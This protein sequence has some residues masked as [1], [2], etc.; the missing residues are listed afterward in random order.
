MGATR[1]VNFSGISGAITVVL[2]W[3]YGGLQ[4][5][6]GFEYPLTNET[7]ASITA[8]VMYLVGVFTKDWMPNSLEDLEKFKVPPNDK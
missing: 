2:L 7:A 6:V 1:S 3:L 8:I 5:W 4:H